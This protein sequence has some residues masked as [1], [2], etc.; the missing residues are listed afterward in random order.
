MGGEGGNQGQIL[1]REGGGRK[2]KKRSDRLAKCWE[3]RRNIGGTKN[4][5]TE[6]GGLLVKCLK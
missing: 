4:A 5:D 6:D 1:K 3:D 2:K